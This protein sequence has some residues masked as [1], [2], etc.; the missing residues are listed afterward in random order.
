MPTRH[1]RHG[2]SLRP[3]YR[4]VVLRDVYCDAAVGSTA[5]ISEASKNVAA[6]TGYEI[7]IVVRQ[8]LIEV[9]ADVELWD[10]VPDDD[11]SAYGWTGPLMF[12]LDCPTGSLQVGDMGGAITGIDPPE[13]PGRYA[14]ALFHRGREQADGARYEI[15]KVMG[16]DG[17]D[18]C[19]AD[20]QR[21]H[22]GI[23]QY[24][25]RI[26]WQADLPP[27]EDDEDL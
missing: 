18:G 11:L 25:M 13:G 10:A 2:L 26:W 21:Q 9:R 20:L 22:Y 1:S 3:D 17:D 5:A 4:M 27:D 6:S 19:I 23:E 16:A 15:L 8:D 7:Y 12:D 14:V 24:L